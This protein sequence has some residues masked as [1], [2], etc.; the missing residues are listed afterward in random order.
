MLSVSDLTLKFSEKPLFKDVNLKFMK[1][2]CYGII[3]A[4]GAGK[5]TFLKIL[6]GEQ[7][8]DS[9]QVS[10]TPGEMALANHGILFADEIMEFPSQV[11]DLMRKPL[12]EREVRLFRNGIT[13]TYPADLIFV[14]AGNPCKCGM[15]YEPGSRCRCSAGT[16]KR[17][18]TRLSGP[19]LERIDIF[20]E[21]RSIGKDDL[22][23][24]YADKGSAESPAVKEK[25]EMILASR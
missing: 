16:R 11:L 13:Y 12:E 23:L 3:G 6:S 19:F 7:D 25:V 14:G 22:A 17:Y 9:G 20:S 24:M 1:G 10:M 2:N 21:M 5:S 8:F 18:L 15:F 4:N